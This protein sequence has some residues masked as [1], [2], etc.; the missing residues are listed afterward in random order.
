[1]HR[2]CTAT[3]CA[4]CLLAI[5]THAFAG[6]GLWLG[7]GQPDQLWSTDANW[8]A[9]SV[10]EISPWTEIGDPVY[11]TYAG[12]G[13]TEGPIIEDGIDAFAGQIILGWAGN[14]VNAPG[15]TVTM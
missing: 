9:G 5:T 3:I 11:I 1:M 7:G 10:P 4:T 13:E 8:E 12:S 15:D 14:W 2:K 6:G